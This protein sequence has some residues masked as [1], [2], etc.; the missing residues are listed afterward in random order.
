MVPE[1]SPGVK[2]LVEEG[3]VV[4]GTSKKQIIVTDDVIP[5]TS[6]AIIP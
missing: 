3:K 1:S 6:K 2:Q 4:G 5:T